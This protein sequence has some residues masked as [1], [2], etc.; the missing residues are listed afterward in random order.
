MKKYDPTLTTPY[1]T[2]KQ[3]TRLKYQF[4][5]EWAHYYISLE[6]LNPERF[7]TLL[8]NFQ[9]EVQTYRIQYARTDGVPAAANEFFRKTITHESTS[10]KVPNPYTYEEAL[11]FARTWGLVSQDLDRRY[12]KLITGYGD[13]SYEDLRDALPLAGKQICE[14]TYANFQELQGTIQGLGP[15]FAQIILHGENYFRM[16]LDEA[17]KKWYLHTVVDAAYHENAITAQTHQY[18]TE[19]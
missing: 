2:A 3:L 9:K 8:V 4:H 14:N 10:P 7:W 11:H 13:D 18:S 16:S 19:D 5:E 15:H 12:G 1:E 17:A 6:P